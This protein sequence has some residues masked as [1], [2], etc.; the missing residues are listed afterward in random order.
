MSYKCVQAVEMACLPDFFDCVSAKEHI[1]ATFSLGAWPK[2]CLATCAEAQEANAGKRWPS[3]RIFVYVVAPRHTH[4]DFVD[5]HLELES[6]HALRT[7]HV[8]N[9]QFISDSTC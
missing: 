6:V 3:A 5:C 7:P 2:D 1:A 9:N 4:H 8:R